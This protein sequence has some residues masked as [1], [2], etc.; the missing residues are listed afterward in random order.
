FW[1]ELL[2]VSV[3]CTLGRKALMGVDSV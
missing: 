3:G 2:A 1:G